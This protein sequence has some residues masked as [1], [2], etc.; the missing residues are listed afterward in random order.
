M[1]DIKKIA[2]DIWANETEEHKQQ[3]K[4]N[5]NKWCEWVIN[6]KIK[7]SDYVPNDSHILMG[8]IVVVSYN[9]ALHGPH[10]VLGFNP[11]GRMF[12]DWGIYRETIPVECVVLHATKSKKGR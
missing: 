11:D 4:R 2:I 8:D 3:R 6:E 5:M 7:K 9:G 10:E 1:K 12:I